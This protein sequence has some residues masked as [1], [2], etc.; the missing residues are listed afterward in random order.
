MN[1]VVLVLMMA[2]TVEALVEY[3]KSIGKAII[4]GEAKTAITQLSAVL[5]SVLLCFAVGADFY[6]ALGVTFAWPWVGNLL[7][8]LF[9]SRGANFV[10]DLIGKLQ[11]KRPGG[12][13]AVVPLSARSFCIYACVYSVASLFLLRNLSKITTA[14]TAASTD[15]PAKFSQRPVSPSGQSRKISNTGKIRA[16]DTDRIDAGTGFSIASI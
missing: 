13:T 11:A 12:I 6:S 2:V 14:R 7:T 10:S 3:G 1:M 16:V 5:I 15:V 8:G 9:A 4:A